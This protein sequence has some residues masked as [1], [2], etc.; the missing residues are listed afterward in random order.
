MKTL[1]L[2]SLLVLSVTTYCQTLSLESLI[3]LR[4]TSDFS[5]ITDYLSERKYIF[6]EKQVISEENYYTYAYNYNPGIKSAYSWFVKMGPYIRY[7]TSNKKFI[8]PIV[9]QL[10]T[11]RVNSGSFSGSFPGSEKY[12]TGYVYYYEYSG[13]YIQ[14]WFEDVSSLYS[15]LILNYVTN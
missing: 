14:I 1:L 10:K 7:Y 3:Y 9:E 2:L 4:K 13:Y 11:Y 15:I 8:S 12:R 5:T 6:I